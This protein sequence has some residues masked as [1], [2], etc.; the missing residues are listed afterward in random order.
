MEQRA[1][2]NWKKIVTNLNLIAAVLGMVFFF[3]KIQLPQ[4]IG[5]AVGNLAATVGPISMLMLG[6][7]MADTDWK[8]LFS[9]SRIYAIVLLKML[10]IPGI[11]LFFLK[12]SPL[13]NL[14][15]SGQR[16]LLITLMAVITPSATTVVQLAQLYRQ[17]PEY[18]SAINIVTT[19]VSIVTMPLLVSVY[20][21]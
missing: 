9:S 19:L 21:W 4:I 7:T 11:V 14:S 18:A 2:F 10:V 1:K 17:K 6:M 5:S 15:E 8:G 3:G 20:L 16:I 12:Y 13:A